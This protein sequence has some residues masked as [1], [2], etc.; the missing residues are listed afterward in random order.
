MQDLHSSG[1]VQK[2]ADD[3]VLSMIQKLSI[4][5]QDHIVVQTPLNEVLPSTYLPRDVKSLGE[6]FFE[7]ELKGIKVNARLLLDEKKNYLRN[8]SQSLEPFE[9][10]YK[11]EFDY[12]VEQLQTLKKTA[13]ELN[14]I[15]AAADISELINQ[16]AGD[17]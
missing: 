4:T 14:N 6:R 15:N 10:V 1:T 3:E 11:F 8:Q 7:V 13:A 5:P 16:L 2:N 17:K 12:L 9:I